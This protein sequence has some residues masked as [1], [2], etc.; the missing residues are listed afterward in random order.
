MYYDWQIPNK[1]P[2]IQMHMRCIYE[3]C[4]F[5]IKEKKRALNTRV[6]T[7]KNMKEYAFLWERQKKRTETKKRC[8]T[9]YGPLFLQHMHYDYQIL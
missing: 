6:G 4:S 7:R 2:I 5:W 9:N 8:C 3:S 1:I